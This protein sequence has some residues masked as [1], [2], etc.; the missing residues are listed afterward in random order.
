[1]E[2]TK[3][4][5]SKEDKYFAPYAPEEQLGI[6]KATRWTFRKKQE[7]VMKASEPLDTEKGL[8][9]MDLIDFQVYQILACIVPPEGS[10]WTK[11]KVE[12]LDPHLGDIILD[13]CRKVNATTLSERQGFLEKSDSEENTPG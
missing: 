4:P 6:Y 13:A 10:E 8:I 11:E 9:E 7:A 1:M 12:N 2:I 3:K 5:K